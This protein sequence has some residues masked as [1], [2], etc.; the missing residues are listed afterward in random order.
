MYRGG[1]AMKL[2]QGLMLVLSLLGVG[3]LAQGCT[4]SAEEM[5]KQWHGQKENVQKYESKYPGFKDALEAL[6]NDGQKDFDE[7]KKADEKSR[8]DKMKAING[9]VAESLKV[10][11]SYET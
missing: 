5:E 1:Y 9:R 3:A 10:F 8:A 11:E 7:A 6:L 2:V 4:P